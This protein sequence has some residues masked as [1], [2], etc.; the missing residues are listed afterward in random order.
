MDT[1]SIIEIAKLVLGS[2]GL[3][4][5]CVLLVRTGKVLKTVDVLEYDQREFRKEMK[6]MRSEFHEEMREMNGRLSTE[7]KA[8]NDRINATSDR[9]SAEIKAANDRISTTSDRL[10]AEIKEMSSKLD[11]A[12]AP[13]R[14]KVIRLDERSRLKWP[15]VSNDD[16]DLT[17]E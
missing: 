4:A 2:G 8:T 11:F 6:E 13:L 1:T 5:L 16:D 15:K 7:I 9:L 17:A 3:A 10:S 12:I 14:E